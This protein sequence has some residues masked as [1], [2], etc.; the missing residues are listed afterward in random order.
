MF[1]KKKWLLQLYE[2]VFVFKNEPTIATKTRQSIKFG[3][4]MKIFVVM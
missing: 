2:R 3:L 4:F 1:G